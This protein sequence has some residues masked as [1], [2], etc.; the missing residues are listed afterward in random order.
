[1]PRGIP[2]KNKTKKSA[3]VLTNELIKANQIAKQELMRLYGVH[4][5]DALAEAFKKVIEREAA[6]ELKPTDAVNHPNH[7]NVGGE[8]YEVIKVLKAW[9]LI[10]NFPLGNAIKYIARAD[11]KKAPIEDLKK[12]VFYINWEIADREKELA[13]LAEGKDKLVVTG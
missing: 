8:Q 10:K 13:D 9:G 3:D 7:Y 2:N 11:H 4:D 12:A 6:K 1:M 5:E